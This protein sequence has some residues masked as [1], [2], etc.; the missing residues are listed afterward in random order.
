LVD[1]IVADTNGV[2]QVIVVGRYIKV[3]T[4]ELHPPGRGMFLGQV[5]LTDKYL[6]KAIEM[7]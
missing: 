5:L 2:G 1:W 7:Y 4:H 3:L 6:Q